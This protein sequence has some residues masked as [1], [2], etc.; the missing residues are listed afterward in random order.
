MHKV[1]LTHDGTTLYL[2]EEHSLL[3]Q[4]KENGLYVKSSCGGHAS[5]S[6]CIVKITEGQG[7]VNEPTFAESQ[8]LGNVFHITKER[9]SCQCFIK[10]EVSI[11]LSGHNLKDDEQ[12][13][14]NKSR[15]VSGSIKVRKKEEVDKVISERIQKSKEKREARDNETWKNHWEKDKSKE[16][17]KLGGGMRPKKLKDL[18]L[19][20][21]KK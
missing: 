16:V 1:N 18:S 14:Q 11:D 10:G 5:C 3:D 2:N 9:L 8:L 20:K 21:N 15:K 19:E 6:D 12:R 13:R 7:N 17:K 4:L